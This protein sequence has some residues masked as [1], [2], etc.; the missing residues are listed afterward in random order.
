MTRFLP[1]LERLALFALLYV[2]WLLVYFGV[3]AWSMT[4]PQLLLAWDPVA[5]VP[6]VSVFVLP[7]LSAYVMP[8]LLLHTMRDLATYRKYALAVAGTIAVSAV[9]FILL[10]LTIDRPDVL[11]TSIFDRL[12]ASLYA[13]DLPTNLFPSL[14]VSLAF[15]FAFGVSYDRPR[16][17]FSMLAWAVLIAVSTLFT[18]QHYVVDA[19]AGAVLAWVA[20]R[21]FLK[22]KK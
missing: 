4:R 18:R 13:N 15:L 5:R 6:M 21:I 1:L 22:F 2:L 11:G 16:W 14:H 20:W 12:L 3:G 8:L 10:P 17:K 7:Y 19:L 9:F